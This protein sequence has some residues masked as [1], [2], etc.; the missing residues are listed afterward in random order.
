MVKVLILYYLNIKAT[1]G[2]EIQKFIQA[3]GFEAWTNIKAGSIYYALSKMDKNGEI[4]LVREENRG[5]RVRRIYE[6]TDLGVIELKK[7]IEKELDKPLVPLNID[8]FILPIT[9]NKLD[10]DEAISII[11][12]RIKE[13]NKKLE[14]WNYW[15]G[16]KINDCST[17]VE[18]LSFEMTICNYEY[19]IKWHESLIEEF[20]LYCEL[21]EKNEVMIKS[22][23]FAELDEKDSEDININ[24]ASLKELKNIILNDPTGAKNALERLITI[25]GEEKN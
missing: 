21:S 10:K 25:I 18:R 20:D 8:K 5:S 7:E 9:F 14:Y 4:R 1:H 6:I 22:F 2:Y 19:E 11:E 16:I 23:N 3:S 15:K 13:L 24:K 12:E 17:Q